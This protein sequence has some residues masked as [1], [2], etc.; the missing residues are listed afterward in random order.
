MLAQGKLCVSDAALVA[1]GTLVDVSAFNSPA[2]LAKEALQ[3]SW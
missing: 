1:G 2:E 3:A